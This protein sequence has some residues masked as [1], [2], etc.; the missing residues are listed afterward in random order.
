[1]QGEA[2]EAAGRTFADKFFE[3]LILGP[4]ADAVADLEERAGRVER[5]AD[6]ER[7][8]EREGERL[9]AENMLPGP[10]RLHGEGGVA[11]GGQADVH[12]VGGDGREG[13]VQVGED[14]HGAKLE[15]RGLGPGRVGKGVHDGD[16]LGSGKAGVGLGVH[17]AHKTEADDDDVQIGCFHG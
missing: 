3:G 9:L 12:D 17:L 7:L 6:F 10:Q 8:V 5:L 4:E 16:D 2:E 13:G 14:G 11:V 15:P 1:L